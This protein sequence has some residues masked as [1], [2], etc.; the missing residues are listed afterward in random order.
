MISIECFKGLPEEYES[1]LIEKYKS[2]ITTCR[3]IEIYYPTYDNNYMLVYENTNLVDVL[4]FGNKGNICTCYNSLVKIDQNIINEFTKELFKNFPEIKK[5]QIAASY[6]SYDL[7][8]S[9][10][11]SES[12]DYILNLPSTIDEYYLGLGS[13]TRRHVKNYKARLL[14]DYPEVHFREKIKNEIDESMI[15]KIVQLSFDRMKFKGIIPGKD[16][17]DTND[18]YRYSQH[19]GCVAYVEI[20]GTIV[21]G[22]ISYILDQRIFL[23]MVAHDNDFSRYNLGQLC[24][25]YLIQTSIE[26]KLKTF[27]FLWGEN[28]YKMKLSAKPHSL[29]SYTIYQAYS[30]DFVISNVRAV[31]SRFVISVRLSRYS[32]PLRDVIKFF[33]RKRYH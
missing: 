17:N 20:N 14:R 10:L 25:I 30:L 23:Y 7:K 31:F 3:Y 16:H 21:A 32:K 8:K 24:I 22:C 9:F 26:K 15:D 11:F 18:F 29:L 13:T 12:N 19:Y 33:R 2:Y 27:H 5:I 6:L 28:D 4:I 1:F